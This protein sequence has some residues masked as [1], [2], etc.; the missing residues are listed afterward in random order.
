[1]K[2]ICQARLLAVAVHVK[3]SKEK[4]MREEIEKV[5]KDLQLWTIFQK[6]RLVDMDINPAPRAKGF[7]GSFKATKEVRTKFKK[8]IE[9]V[10]K[11]T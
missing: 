11:L 3:F 1:M 9:K 10:N 2:P 4:S 5:I 7:N 8:L 6:L